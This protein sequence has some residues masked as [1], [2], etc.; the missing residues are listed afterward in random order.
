[1]SEITPDSLAQILR[2]L[3]EYFDSNSRDLWHGLGNERGFSNEKLNALLAKLVLRAYANSPCINSDI[4]LMA[5]GLLEG[6][7]RQDY[8]VGKRR[9]LFL[10]NNEDFF[11]SQAK[12]KK[13]YLAWKSSDPEISA[14]GMERGTWNLRDYEGR[15][16]KSLS[17]SI[18]EWKSSDDWGSYIRD[19]DGFYDEK[20]HRAIWQKPSSILQNGK[21]Q[22]DIPEGG[23]QS[24]AEPEHEPEPPTSELEPLTEPTPPSDPTKPR[25][26]ALPLI[27]AACVLALIVAA[28][29]LP[30][31]INNDKPVVGGDEQLAD[32][33]AVVSP[34][35][36]AP[37]SATAPPFSND[38]N[39][40]QASAYNLGG[41]LAD[42][43]WLDEIEVERGNQYLVRVWVQNDSDFPAEGVALQLRSSLPP[44]FYDKTVTISGHLSWGKDAATVENAVSF[45]CD[46]PFAVEF[47]EGTGRYLCGGMA[48]QN[49]RGVRVSDNAFREKSDAPLGYNTF[50]GVIPAGEQYAG[51]YTVLVRAVFETE[52][53]ASWGP[54]RELFTVENPP[55]FVIL[56][57]ITDS[58]AHGNEADFVRIKN[59][60][61]STYSDTMALEPG[62]E[63]EVIAFYDNDALRSSLSELTNFA[64]GVRIK[65][66]FP[67]VIEAGEETHASM[68]LVAENAEPQAVWSSIVL[69][70][71]TGDIFIRY[72]PDSATIYNNGQTNSTKLDSATLFSA[73]GALLGYDALDGVI[74]SGV[75]GGES[76]N[77]Y[78]TFR[79]VADHPNFEVKTGLRNAPGDDWAETVEAKAGDTVQCM[80]MYKNTGTTQQNNV[81][82]KAMLPAGV[83]FVEGSGHIRNGDNLNT[84]STDDIT[85]IG[86]NVGNYNPGASVSVWFEVAI[87][88]DTVAQNGTTRLGVIG[89]AETD[90]GYKENIAWIDIQ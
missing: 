22:G 36:Q 53:S 43:V 2:G 9:E 7:A 42:A 61:E 47:I 38:W 24:A 84:P 59:V 12:W 87:A 85:G 70:S 71:D 37:T 90:N 89:R 76:F 60:N 41:Q 56:N 52:L 20:T 51:C 83:S 45:I 57:S 50:D 78:V 67:E 64:E 4:L 77:G 21:E 72:V 25:R 46:E 40:V 13:N 23:F 35:P 74:P 86:L 26:K 6:Y 19:F 10:E 34:T 31:L 1:M 63:Y 44:D 69:T 48:S 15:L 88:P 27:V 16:I 5:F 81:N 73:E 62:E 58:L 82:I 14:H 8:S 33:G 17:K 54:P 32:T 79:F 3:R 30:H 68:R 49:E 18:V 75:S 65:A 39:F 28:V 11:K 66:S 55:S 29:G 80:I